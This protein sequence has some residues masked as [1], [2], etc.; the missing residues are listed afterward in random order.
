MGIVLRRVNGDDFYR[1]FRDMQREID[2]VFSG[3][4]SN[5]KYTEKKNCCSPNVDVYETDKSFVLEFEL[6]GFKKEDININIEDNIISVESEQKF[7]EE[8]K[9]RN[10]HII[11]RR[12]GSFKRQFTLPENSDREN[13]HAKFNEGILEVTIDKKQEEKEEKTKSV[14]IE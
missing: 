13:I 11:E 14:E 2:N 9:D 6:P 12:Y 1:T 3:V 7:E 4:L 5:G 10:Y 8:K